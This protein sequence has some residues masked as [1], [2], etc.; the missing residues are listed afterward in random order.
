MEQQYNNIH[1]D[2]MATYFHMLV[3]KQPKMNLVETFAKKHENIHIE[4][5]SFVL[6]GGNV[7]H[8]HVWE[9]IE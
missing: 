5:I 3:H 4:I 1:S 8:L 6:H 9:Y 7:V 2:G